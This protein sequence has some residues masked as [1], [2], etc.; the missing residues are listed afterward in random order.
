MKGARKRPVP[1]RDEPP[2]ILKSYIG[3]RGTVT[4]EQSERLGISVRLDG[5][6]AGMKLSRRHARYLVNILVGERV[7]ER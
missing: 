3:V 5:Q 4:V 1:K 2:V 7:Y 6:L